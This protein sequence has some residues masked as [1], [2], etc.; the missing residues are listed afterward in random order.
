MKVDEAPRPLPA[1]DQGQSHPT[2]E[3]EAGDDLNRQLAIGRQVDDVEHNE[4]ESTITAT[5][6]LRA[7]V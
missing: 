2:W 7:P 4:G 3:P 5:V 6:T 1:R